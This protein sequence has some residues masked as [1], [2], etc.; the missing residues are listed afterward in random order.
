MYYPLDGLLRTIHKRSYVY[1]AFGLA[2][3]AVR[4][5]Y[6]LTFGLLHRAAGLKLSTWRE[7]E[8][9]S[10]TNSSRIQPG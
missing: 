2:V 4:F 10:H 7:G 8:M 3:H 6:V 1:L 5:Q 9:D